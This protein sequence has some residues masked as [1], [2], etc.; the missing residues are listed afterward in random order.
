MMG[1]IRSSE[2]LVLIR[3]TRCNIPQEGI[4][5][6]GICLTDFEG[7]CIYLTASVV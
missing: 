5:K 1:T 2:T 4:L 3:A 7:Q 6:D